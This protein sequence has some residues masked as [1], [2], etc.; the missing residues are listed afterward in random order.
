MSLLANLR[1]VAEADGAELVLGWT[2]PEAGRIAAINEAGDR[3]KRGRP[4]ARPVVLPTVDA[5][6]G[7]ISDMVARAIAEAARGRGPERALGELGDRLVEEARAR[8]DARAGWDAPHNAPS[9][10]RRKGFDAPL[11]GADKDRIYGGLS[12][13]VRK[14]R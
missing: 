3:A 4:P 2:D 10:I 14:R 7:L 12:S 8:I 6:A 13:Q 9:T 11:R 5:S 1:A